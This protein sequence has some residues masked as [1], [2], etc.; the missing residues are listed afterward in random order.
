MNTLCTD[1]RWNIYT[2]VNGTPMDNFKKVIEDLQKY[3]YDYKFYNEITC[4]YPTCNN[5][6][7]KKDASE[8]T[9][10]NKTLGYYCSENCALQDSYNL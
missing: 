5:T 9:I 7:L 3:W 8:I 10:G 1:T 4:Y 6:C 2:F